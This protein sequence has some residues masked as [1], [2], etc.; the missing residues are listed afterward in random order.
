MQVNNP[1]RNEKFVWRDFLAEMAN[2]QVQMDQHPADC[3]AG[4]DH[5]SMQRLRFRTIHIRLLAPMSGDMLL[6]R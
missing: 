3:A 2:V 6:E 1:I 4:A 5:L